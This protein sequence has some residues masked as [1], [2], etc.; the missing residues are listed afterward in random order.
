MLLVGGQRVSRLWVE[1]IK[2]GEERFMCSV[3]FETSL[4]LAPR[5]RDFTYCAVG[6]H[7]FRILE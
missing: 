6:E 4:Q 7:G 1:G 2:K 5:F 3:V